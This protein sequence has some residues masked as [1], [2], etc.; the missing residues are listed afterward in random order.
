MSMG[1]SGADQIAAN[2]QSPVLSVSG[3]TTSFLRERRWIPVVCDV[4]F[5]I[6]SRETV[7]IVGESGSG[8]SVTA[9]SIMRLIPKE[10]GRVEGSVR[11]AGSRPADAARSEHEG[12]SWQRN[13]HDLPGANDEPQSG[14]DH[15]LPDCGSTDPA[16]RP[17][18]RGGGGRDHMPARPR[19]DTCGEIALPRASASLLRRHAPARNDRDGAG[20]QAEAADRRR[21][22]HRA[23]RHDPGPDPGASEGA[24]AGRGDVDP[25][26]HPRHGGG[27]RDRGPHRGDVWRPGSGNRCDRAHLC[28][29][30]ASLYPLAARGRATPRLDGRADAADAFSDR[31]QGDGDL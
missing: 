23:R 3:L 21:A 30:L 22:D 31:R 27:G 20:L 7:A 19:A 8:K 25:L 28:F 4:S 1:A 15:R 5:D 11:L 29:T 16:P 14:A 9:L 6:A 2:A 10:N 12:C 24:S 13:R 26:H 18:A 17:V